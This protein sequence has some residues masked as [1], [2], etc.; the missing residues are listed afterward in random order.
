MVNGYLDLGRC[1][2]AVSRLAYFTRPC[3]LDCKDQD[4]EL[5]LELL[6]CSSKREKWKIR[7]TGSRSAGSFLGPGRRMKSQG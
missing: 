2:E 1:N 3:Q 4:R 5:E 7:I 6:F